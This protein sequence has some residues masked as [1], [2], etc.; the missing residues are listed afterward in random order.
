MKKIIRSVMIP[1]LILI[2][3][4]IVVEIIFRIEANR[5]NTLTRWKRHLYQTDSIVGYRY[6]SDTS[7]FIQN[8]AYSK[9]NHS[10]SFGF[11]GDEFTE[12]KEI[13][14]KRIILVG[15]SDD[16]GVN[17]NGPYSYSIYL[18][19][20]L[21][22]KNA[23]IEVLN[24]AIDGQHR[25]LLNIKLI[26]AELIHYQP[27]III[28]RKNRFPMTHR[29]RYRETYKDILINCMS[30]REFEGAENY[31]DSIIS[32]KP[33][34][35]YLFDCSY[36]F[37]KVSKYYLDNVVKDRNSTVVFLERLF[38]K[39][40]MRINMYA[41]REIYW[42]WDKYSS[43]DLE[44]TEFTEDESTNIYRELN[45]FLEEWGCKLIVFDAY[46]LN[47]EYQDKMQTL[48]KNINIIYIPLNVKFREEYSF[49]EKDGHSS[50]LGHKAIG[51]ALSVALDS[52]I[53]AQ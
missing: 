34:I 47:K 13:G 31:V 22:E 15:T 51:T 48:F 6:M 10:N 45:L 32:N 14:H 16:A 40:R 12:Q 33:F 38:F 49:G 46:T 1:F 11:I 39:N 52:I 20:L 24:C 28:L 23:K 18:E 50:Q 30:I 9:W 26:K 3:G 2:G 7:W 44:E 53:F 42:N 5:Q 17:T 29:M 4:I 43:K 27:D 41:R 19:Q 35:H 8:N 21:K 37:R 36:I 25:Q